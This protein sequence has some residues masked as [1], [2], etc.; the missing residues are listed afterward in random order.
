MSSNYN[1]SNTNNKVDIELKMFE[2]INNKIEHE[3]NLFVS[4]ITWFISLQALLF[5]PVFLI[6]SQTT[7]D[8]KS[9]T[10]LSQTFFRHQENLLL[11]IMLTGLC[12]C[13]IVLLGC[14]AG[15]LRVSQ[16]ME[17]YRQK[18]NQ[19]YQDY[20]D[21]FHVILDIKSSP[22]IRLL[23]LIA[24]FGSIFIFSKLWLFLEVIAGINKNAMFVS[25]IIATIIDSI[26]MHNLFDCVFD[27]LCYQKPQKVFYHVMFGIVVIIVNCFIFLYIVFNKVFLLWILGFI[28]ATVMFVLFK[29]LFKVKLYICEK[30]N[31]KKLKKRA[32]RIDNIVKLSRHDRDDS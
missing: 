7:E 25:F 1:Q 5:F 29:F 12:F 8:S 30:E 27:F 22:W 11:G 16:L 17:L 28:V 19:F 20:S 32:T 14:Q 23:C 3:D 24:S 10:G 26:I 9:L 15:H 21:Y 31:Y 6:F 2:A 18:R 4:R 13:F